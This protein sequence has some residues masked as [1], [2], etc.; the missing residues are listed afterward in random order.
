M[1]ATKDV[2]ILRTE[3]YGF[4]LVHTEKGFADIIRAL[5]LE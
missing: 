4:I 2:R 3:T 5:D 1:M